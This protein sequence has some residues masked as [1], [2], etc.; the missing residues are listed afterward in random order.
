MS[1]ELERLELFKFN[2]VDLLAHGFQLSQP[3]TMLDLPEYDESKGV[4]LT[5]MSNNEK[6]LYELGR[7]LLRNLNSRA[8]SLPSMGTTAAEIEAIQILNS[9]ISKYTALQD[10]LD[11]SISNRHEGVHLHVFGTAS[12]WV[13][14]CIDPMCEHCATLDQTSCVN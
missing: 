10:L 14:G 13:V 7:I 9:D 2:L 1:D 11:Q 3:K 12:G 6:L 4:Q 8:D 5:E